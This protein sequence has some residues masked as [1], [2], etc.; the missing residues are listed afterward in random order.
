[1]EKLKLQREGLG[2]KRISFHKDANAISVKAKL[3]EVYPRLV[4]GGGFEILRSGMSPKDMHLLT[5]PANS[6]Y[7]VQCL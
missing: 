5:L 2:R 6:G 3:E 4:A 1:M 7:S